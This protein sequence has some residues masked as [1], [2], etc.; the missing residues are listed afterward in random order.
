MLKFLK[1]L[2]LV[3]SFNLVLL[4]AG[5]AVVDLTDNAMDKDGMDLTGM[6]SYSQADNSMDRG[7]R[8]EPRG[9]TQS[10]TAFM[11][12]VKNQMAETVS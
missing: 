8:E 7:T 12:A 4:Q 10:E 11:D 6:G 1:C 3:K 2:K 9:D 5:S